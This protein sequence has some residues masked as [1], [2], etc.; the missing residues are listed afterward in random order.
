MRKILFTLFVLMM[1]NSVWA[2][3]PL[4]S[5]VYVN[6]KTGVM[7]TTIK[8]D[9]KKVDDFVLPF[10]IAL[11]L[12]LRHMRVEA[13][14]T[15]TTKAKK[16]SYEQQTDTI[17]AQLYDDVPFK[18]AIRPF[19]NIGGGR[20]DADIKQKKIKE[21][22]EKIVDIDKEKKAISE[23]IR[24][25]EMFKKMQP[26]YE[27]YTRSKNKEKYFME[28]ETS[29]TLYEGSKS[30]LENSGI[31]PEKISVEDL[32]TTL[33][34][35]EQKRSTLKSDNSSAT[36]ELDDLQRKKQTLDKYFK[37]DKEQPEKEKQK[38]QSKHR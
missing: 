29:I 15:F 12:R 3:A 33:T 14:Y 23:Q 35:L 21:N 9:G 28:H 7:R 25:L 20:Y 32:K 31:N 18:S 26:F 22:R 24:Y 36:K 11:G 13:E 37:R 27:E 16:E 1:T 34:N 10:S 4:R 6:S 17:M 2:A 5:G 30:F 38:S 8:K 19:F